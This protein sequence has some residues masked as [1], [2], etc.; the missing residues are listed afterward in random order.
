[1]GPAGNRDLTKVNCDGRSHSGRQGRPRTS[2]NPSLP[3]SSN[4]LS[5]FRDS[6]CLSVPPRRG[7]FGAGRMGD[8]EWDEIGVG[9]FESI[10]KHVDV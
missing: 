5:R 2:L 6:V 3:L 10:A 9:F 8:D 7:A 1:M 4:S